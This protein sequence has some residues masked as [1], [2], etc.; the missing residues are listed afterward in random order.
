MSYWRKF[1]ILLELKLDG[2]YQFDKFTLME[3]IDLN[4]QKLLLFLVMKQLPLITID[5]F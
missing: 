1:L 4:K 2:V 5:K 3:L